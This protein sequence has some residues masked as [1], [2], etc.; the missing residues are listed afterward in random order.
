MGSGGETTEYFYEV[1]EEK[2]LPHRPEC[3]LDALLHVDHK[4]YKILMNYYLPQPIFTEAR[5]VREI[6]LK[7]RDVDKYREIL[8]PY[9]AE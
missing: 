6:L 9:F 1:L 4:N 5:E 8:R 3:F 7:Y 2:F